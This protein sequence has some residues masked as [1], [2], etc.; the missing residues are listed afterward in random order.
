[1]ARFR[2]DSR[3][4]LDIRSLD[5]ILPSMT[6][7]GPDGRAIWLPPPIVKSDIIPI[8]NQGL[9]ID[10]EIFSQIEDQEIISQPAFPIFPSNPSI[11]VVGAEQDFIID[12]EGILETA[13]YLGV[14][15]VFIPSYHD[16]MLG[17]KWRLSAN[18]IAKWLEAL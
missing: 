9:D 12:K 7:G 1:M 11:L 10:M 2:A 3:V 15:P 6:S 17:P 8:F 13:V 18:V 16:V 5:A 14:E 4:T